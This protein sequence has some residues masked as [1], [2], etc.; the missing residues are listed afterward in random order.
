MIGYATS[1]DGFAWT[2]NPNPVLLLGQARAWDSSDVAS[3]SVVWNGTLFLMWYAGKSNSTES[4]GLAFS[5]DGISWTK[6]QGNPVMMSVSHDIYPYVIRV[7][8]T[9]KMWYT[10]GTFPTLWIDSAA[11]ADGIHWT[12]NP[13]TAL[14][15]DAAYG[16]P[17]SW[18][19]VGIY[20]PSVIYNGSAYWMWYTGGSKVTNLATIGYATSKDGV[21]FNSWTKSPDNPIVS[22]G[23]AGA[24]DS[25]DYIQYPDAIVV[26]NGVML[27]YSAIQR[28]ANGT[29]VSEKIG[30]AQSPQGF[31]VAE[32]PFPTLTLLLG[33]MLLTTAA[34]T[35]RFRSNHSSS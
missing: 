35:R 23:P 29:Y 31:S 21:T 27:Y 19:G 16:Q 9:Y 15:P 17:N 4:N 7:G 1:P 3:G 25:Y 5:S 32:L 6:Y 22:Q 34:V 13:G 14:E 2:K 20:S 11:S 24:W 33:V 26:D 28:A 12:K 30:L 18:D 8:N 10:E